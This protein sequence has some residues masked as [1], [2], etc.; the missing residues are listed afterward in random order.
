MHSAILAIVKT[1]L[2]VSNLFPRPD[3]TRNG[4]FNLAFAGALHAHLLA[5]GG[6]LNVLVPVPEWRFWRWRR[7]R[8]WS[9]PVD[10]EQVGR[11][12]RV[13]YVPCFYLPIVGRSLSFL[14]YEAAFRSVLDFAG[15]CDAVIGSWLYPDAVAAKYLASH[16]AKP[17]WIR[18]HGTDRFHLDAPIRGWVCQRAVAKASGVIVNAAFMKNE[19][20]RRGIPGERIAVV[21][22]GID[23]AVFHPGDEANRDAGTVL[24]VGNMVSIKRPGLAMRVFAGLVRMNETG[25]AV[26]PNR[27]RLVLAGDGPMRRRLVHLAKRL[28][29]DEQVTFT[30]SLSRHEV[31]SWM[32]RA[33]VLLLTSRSEGMPNVVIESLACG[34]PVVSTY[35]GDV[36]GMLS[37]N[38][39]GHVVRDSAGDGLEHGVTAALMD[40]LGA[41]W[42]RDA[43][44]ASICVHDWSRAAASVIRLIE[45]TTLEGET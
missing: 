6:G 21:P 14:W 38:I 31:A 40:A 35:V 25:R 34:T 24:W 23:H 8:A 26:S 29:I 19:L 5:V 33:S 18:L 37:G 3:A 13:R 7:I 20:V 4:M 45:A 36:P 44:Q 2:L 39:N 10:A 11:T 28:R 17:C 32:R 27:L 9:L 30:G 43:I 22:N 1:I 41:K 42:D 16:L 15:G 12:L